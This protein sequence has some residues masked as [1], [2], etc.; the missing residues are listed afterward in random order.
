MS[1]V[2]VNLGTVTPSPSSLPTYL[3]TTLN[4][5]TETE[6][7]AAYITVRTVAIISAYRGSAG[8]DELVSV[9]SLIESVAFE[10]FDWQIAAASS[11]EIYAKIDTLISS[12]KL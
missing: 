2:T 9:Y 5:M 1:A 8:Y 11:V 4:G 7:R 3:M 6:L 10:R 12:G